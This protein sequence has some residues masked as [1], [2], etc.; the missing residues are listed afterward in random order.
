MGAG[1]SKV[2]HV[3]EDKLDWG[4]QNNEMYDKDPE[5]HYNQL[6]TDRDQ[7][8]ETTVNHVYKK[9]RDVF[10]QPAVDIQLNPVNWAEYG[11]EFRT[12]P[13]PYDF[14]AFE[15]L[16]EENP[17]LSVERAKN[18]TNDGE[19]KE[20]QPSSEVP[21]SKN[22]KSPQDKKAAP[23]SGAKTSGD[24][25]D[26]KKKPE[27]SRGNDKKQEKSKGGAKGGKRLSHNAEMDHCSLEEEN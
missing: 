27:K 13:S 4:A 22:G 25:S 24:N 11:I 5:D 7:R 26:D 14:P 2:K 1:C 12:R 17:R 16:K 20:K 10:G 6:N 8:G 3:F 18:R 19:G 9:S 23:T 15:H 21:Q